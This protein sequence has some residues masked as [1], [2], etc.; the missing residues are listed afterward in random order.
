[1]PADLSRPI[2]SCTRDRVL[3]IPDRLVRHSDGAVL[4]HAGGPG[5]RSNDANA[6][7]AGRL[8][9]GTMDYHE[10]APIGVL[11]RLD[12]G[13]P[14]TTPQVEHVTVSNGLGWS[15]DGTTMYYI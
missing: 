8:R 9:H 7:P 11:Y 4:A 2:V 10:S 1:M 6:D 12:P 14:D 15:P 3:Y 13:A 5:V